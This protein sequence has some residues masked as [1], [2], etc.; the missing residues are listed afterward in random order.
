MACIQGEEIS[1]AAGDQEQVVAGAH[2]GT[3]IPG[4]L[5]SIQGN[6][7]LTD[8]FQDGAVITKGV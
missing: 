2:P 7:A 8:Q 5:R 3:D 1:P 4:E 6:P